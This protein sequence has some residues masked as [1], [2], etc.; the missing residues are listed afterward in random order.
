[1][2]I[3]EELKTTNFENSQHKTVL[4]IF[5]SASWLRTRTKTVL[6]KFG[7]SPEQFNVLRILRGQASRALCLKEIT[8]RMIDRSSNTTRIVEKLAGT[9]YNAHNLTKTN[10]NWKL[11]L[12]LK[13]CK[14][15]PK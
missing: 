1:M 3:E 2:T 9:S 6:K 14:Y 12:Q 7:L 15:L 13:D 10:E 4:N 11:L 8:S 5:F